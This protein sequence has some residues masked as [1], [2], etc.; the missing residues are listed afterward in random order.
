VSPAYFFALH[1]YHRVLLQRNAE[2]RRRAFGGLDPWDAQLV[3]LG[4]RL[5]AYRAAYVIRLQPLVTAWFER[6]G[7]I[8]ALQL[9]Y[10]ASWQGETDEE[11]MIVAGGHIRRLR[12]DEV[13]RGVT[14][15][16][17]HR[18]DLD[19]TLDGYPLRSAGSQGQWRTAMLAVRLGE[20]EV[21]AGEL[22]EPPV[23]LLDDALAEL[24]D[25]RQR[26]VLESDAETQVLATATHLPQVRRPVR[27]YQI[28]AGAILGQTWSPRFEKS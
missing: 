4:V 18:D 8:G 12:A 27:A 19:I 5:T 7:G 23:L 28:E 9:L 20:R 26:R 3:A 15:T 22:N 10:R 11:L 2:L 13:R 25:E 16:G 24:D 21:M 6:L 17:P 14:L 1:R